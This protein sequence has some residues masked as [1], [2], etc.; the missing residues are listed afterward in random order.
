MLTFAVKIKRISHTLKTFR[1]LS[2]Y[3]NGNLD[4]SLIGEVFST[5]VFMQI[6]VREYYLRGRCILV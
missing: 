4:I 3:P 2:I 1:I 5:Q 6:S